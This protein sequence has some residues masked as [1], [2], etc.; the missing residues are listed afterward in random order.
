MLIIGALLRPAHIDMHPALRDPT[1]FLRL[2]LDKPLPVDD[3]AA[4]R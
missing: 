4:L 2:V 3:L 1:E